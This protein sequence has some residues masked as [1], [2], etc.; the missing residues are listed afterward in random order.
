MKK[1]SS[2]SST[3]MKLMTLISGSSRRRGRKFKGSRLRGELLAL[4]QRVDQLHRLFLHADD[5]PLHFAA[6]EPIG[7]QRRNRDG[8]SGGGGDQRLADAA[9]QVSRIAEP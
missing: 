8:Q 5:Q 7:D 1:I 2:T 4:V 9:R 3:S 6:Q